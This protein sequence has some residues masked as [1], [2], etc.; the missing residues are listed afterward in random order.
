VLEASSAGHSGFL[1]AAYTQMERAG[2]KSFT[3]LGKVRWRSAG[4]GYASSA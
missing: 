4:A 2:V 3:L 1:E